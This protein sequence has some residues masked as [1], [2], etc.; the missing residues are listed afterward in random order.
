MSDEI[1]HFFDDD[2]DDF[3]NDTPSPKV[4]TEIKVFKPKIEREVLNSLG[5]NKKEA[6]LV[7]TVTVMALFV[8]VL[9]GTLVGYMHW[10]FKYG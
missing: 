8:V 7:W 3:W 5:L 1:I 10:Y 4:K 6:E 9:V 2:D